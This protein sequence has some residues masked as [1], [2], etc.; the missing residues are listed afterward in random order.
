MTRFA[1]RIL[2]RLRNGSCLSLGKSILGVCQMR[3]LFLSLNLLLALLI[4]NSGGY[5]TAA[6][7]STVSSAKGSY[8]KEIARPG[9]KLQVSISTATEKTIHFKAEKPKEVVVTAKSLKEEIPHLVLNRNGVPTPGF[10]RTLMISVDN[11]PVAESGISVQLVIETQHADPDLDR[12]NRS[13]I[14]VWKESAFFPYETLLREGA[15]AQFRIT[16]DPTL[17]LTDETIQTPTDYY[18][19]R[20][21]VSDARGNQLASYADEYAFLLE[22][23]WRVPLP[24]VLED[25]PGAAPRELLVYYYDMVPFQTDVRD[26]DT[27]IPRQEVGRYIQTELIPEMVKAFELQS[28]LWDLPWYKEWSNHRADEDP[29]TLSVALGGKQTWYHGKA[30]SLGHAMISIRVDGSFGEYSSLTDGIMSVFHHE[31]FHNQQRN[32]SAHYG[33]RGQIS[34]QEEAWKLFTEGTAV[35]ASSVAQPDIQ[36]EAMAQSRSYIRR[37]NDFIGSEGALG[38]GLNKSYKDIPYHTALYWRFL[39]ENCGGLTAEGEDPSTGM[40]IIQ[41]ALETLYKGEIVQINASTDAAGA[42]PLIMDRALQSTP[43]C[44]FHNYEESLVHFARAI[45]QLRLKDSGC[46]ISTEQA[47]CGFM[48]P[49]QLYHSP[50]VDTFLVSAETVTEIRGT[51]SSSYGID[52][53]DLDLGSSMDRKDIKI[54][55]AHSPHS[56][57]AFHVEVWKTRTDLGE[58]GSP[59]AQIVGSIAVSPGDGKMILEVENIGNTPFDGLGLIITRVDPYEDTEP[60]GAYSIQLLAESPAGDRQLSRPTMALHRDES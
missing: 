27:Q 10:E 14:R 36:F 48:D 28:N 21:V 54:V 7:A 22:N 46:L 2:T 8:A 24:P 20:I 5:V 38:G 53:I 37:A 49:H 40:K 23:Q 39:Y 47:N 25:T 17:K 16:F 6:G 41:N 45:F 33:G 44:A 9:S 55:F 11:L 31:L 13:R 57:S 56:S 42:F 60:T 51:I 59:P 26:P 35:L 4:Q 30:P 52:L 34:G 15:N 29:K 12:K 58:Q 1:T 50:P 19:Y 32:I 3:N 43:S 18:R